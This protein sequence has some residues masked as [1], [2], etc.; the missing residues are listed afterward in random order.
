LIRRKVRT[1]RRS[2]L[3]RENLLLFYPRRLEKFTTY[4]PGLL[5]QSAAPLAQARRADPAAKR[6]T[7][8]AITPL[9][10]LEQENLE[11]YQT[12]DA[13]R[14]ALAKAKKRSVKPDPAPQQIPA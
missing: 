7:D 10:D 6:Y 3:P 4:I 5:F 12:N 8:V 13:A 14:S 9:K 11:M 2:T 1:Q